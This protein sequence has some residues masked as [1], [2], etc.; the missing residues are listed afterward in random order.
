MFHKKNA[1]LDYEDMH[2][3]YDKN[4]KEIGELAKE[5]VES[6]EEQF[7]ASTVSNYAKHSPLEFVAEV[8]ARIMNGHKFSDDVMKLYEKYKGPKLPENMA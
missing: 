1:L 8:Y 2:V 4:K 7:I 3:G 6:P 5:F